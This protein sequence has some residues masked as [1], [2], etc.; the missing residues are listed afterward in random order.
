MQEAVQA[1]LPGM[2]FAL[3]DVVGVQGEP[4]VSLVDASLVYSVLACCSVQPGSRYLIGDV[5]VVWVLVVAAGVLLL[6][7]RY[8]SP[9][10]LP[11][12]V[13]RGSHL[14]M[15]GQPQLQR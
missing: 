8:A 10:Y 15:K 3:P 1:F 5:R 6:A 7:V 4:A 9:P 12:S 14:L 13:S 2:C 11:R